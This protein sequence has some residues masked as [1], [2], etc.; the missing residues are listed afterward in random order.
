MCNT[1]NNNE[2]YLVAGL[3][4]PGSAYR[5][6]RHNIGFMVINALAKEL[7]IQIKRVKFKALIGTGKLGTR[8]LILAK[9]Q[10]YMNASGGSISPLVRYFKV[11]IT[12]LIII[13]DD[14]DL[15][16]GAIRIRPAGGTGGQKGMGSIITSLGSQEIPR[17][18]I[19]IGR[20]P[21]RMSPADYVLQ[22]FDAN[23]KP[24]RDEVVDQAV[25]AVI[26]FI[27]EG[28]EKTMNT[29]NGDLG[30]LP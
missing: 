28:L 6:N 1:E 12:N 25:K 21:G 27:N 23:Q 29:Y 7:D 5:E 10:T 26:T 30:K 2:T 18:R 8:S 17:M 19:G 14:L 16:L 11:P 3:G 20:P 4:N 9:P 15:P 13:H 24:L 22:D